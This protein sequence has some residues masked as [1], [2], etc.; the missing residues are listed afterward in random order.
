MKVLIAGDQIQQI[1]LAKGG[2]NWS[3]RSL[4]KTRGTYS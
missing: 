3:A 1:Q 2:M 4:Q